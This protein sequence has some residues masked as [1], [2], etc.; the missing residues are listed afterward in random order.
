MTKPPKGSSEKTTLEKSADAAE[1]KLPPDLERIIAKQRHLIAV[2]A[3]ECVHVFY[4]YP[5]GSS[6]GEKH[7]VGQFEGKMF[8]PTNHE[9][10]LFIK[11]EGCYSAFTYYI[12][13]ED[14]GEP[15]RRWMAWPVFRL[16]PEYNAAPGGTETPAEATAKTGS[17][18]LADLSR[19]ADVLVKIRGDA[20]APQAPEA[21]ALDRLMKAQQRMFDQMQEDADERQKR[22]DKEHR[23]ELD[24]LRLQLRENKKTGDD[25]DAAAGGKSGA[26]SLVDFVDAAAKG[27]DVLKDGKELLGPLFSKATQ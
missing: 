10:G 14:D 21:A 17:D 6:A 19:L 8:P 13:Q 4:R 7:N 3:S 9:F 16:G 22:R 15:E 18:P 20:P 24:R 1:E 27:L 2:N 11:R 26:E 23:E 25:E 5:G 12:A